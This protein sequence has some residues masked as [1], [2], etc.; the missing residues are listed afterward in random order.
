MSIIVVLATPQNYPAP[1]VHHQHLTVSEIQDPQTPNGSR[2]WQAISRLLSLIACAGIFATTMSQGFTY[3]SLGNSLANCFS[4]LRRCIIHSA[5]LRACEAKQKGLVNKPILTFDQINPVRRNRQQLS[6]RWF[7]TSSGIEMDLLYLFSDPRP[8]NNDAGP[9]KR[10]HFH[11]IVLRWEAYAHQSSAR[12]LLNGFL[13]ERFNLLF[14]FSNLIWQLDDIGE[15]VIL[16][17]LYSA[18]RKH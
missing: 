3:V 14:L 6:V 4:V 16:S 7:W 11:G 18:N 13:R 12:G 1:F 5:G 9:S 17:L 2:K 8:R 10:F 15:D